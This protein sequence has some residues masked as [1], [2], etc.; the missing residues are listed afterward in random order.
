MAVINLMGTL[1]RTVPQGL[2][3]Q[4]TLS[5]VAILIQCLKNVINPKIAL[6]DEVCSFWCKYHLINVHN[7]PHNWL[8]RAVRNKCTSSFSPTN[9]SYSLSFPSTCFSNSS[10][11]FFS[12]FQLLYRRRAYST[13]F[14]AICLVKE[15][16]LYG[17]TTT[18]S[19]LLHLQ[20]ATN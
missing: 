10:M 17:R 1:K 3:H 14:S 7:F 8:K 12:H 2:G 19:Q 18:I 4:E 20:H 16:T 15:P 5:E 11:T 6:E 13:H 9:P